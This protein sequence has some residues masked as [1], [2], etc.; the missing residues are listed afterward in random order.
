[1]PTVQGNLSFMVKASALSIK[2]CNTEE[3]MPNTGHRNGFTSYALVRACYLQATSFQNWQISWTS[4]HCAAASPYM[5]AL[6]KAM[7]IGAFAGQTGSMDCAIM[8]WEKHASMWLGTSMLGPQP[9]GR[10]HSTWEWIAVPISPT[11]PPALILPAPWE[12]HAWTCHA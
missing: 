4:Q 11:L 9:S 2:T 5:R 10:G 3:L 6:L 7:T 12:W 8:A 1:M